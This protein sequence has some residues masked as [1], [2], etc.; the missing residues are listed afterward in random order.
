MSHLRRA[1]REV[2]DGFH[3]GLN[4]L[5]YGWPY[6]RHLPAAKSEPGVMRE[7]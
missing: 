2:I 1:A 5:L 7:R 4:L 6:P 3:A